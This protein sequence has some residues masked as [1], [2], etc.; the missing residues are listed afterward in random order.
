M[1]YCK[2]RALLFWGG[3][4]MPAAKTSARTS[5]FPLLTVNRKIA[6]H[7]IKYYMNALK[8]NKYI[9][10]AKSFY[11]DYLS[12]SIFFFNFASC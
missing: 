8:P 5:S 3:Q 2:W 11:T 10:Y 12:F 9:I 4:A 1:I 7:L 6:Q